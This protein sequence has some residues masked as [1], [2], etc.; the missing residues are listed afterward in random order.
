MNLS[1]SNIRL[2]FLGRSRSKFKVHIMNHKI[3]PCV[4]WFVELCLWIYTNIWSFGLVHLS[5]LA[6]P[7]LDNLRRVM[8]LKKKGA[9]SNC[10]GMACKA[11]HKPERHSLHQKN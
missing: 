4:H 1:K 7:W 6:S 8:K 10:E 3:G 5:D 2:A 11:Y 9:W